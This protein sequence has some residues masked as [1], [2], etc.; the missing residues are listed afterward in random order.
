MEPGNYSIRNNILV[1]N[2]P[3]RVEDG[4]CTEFVK[5]FFLEEQLDTYIEYAHRTPGM[6][7]HVGT[8]PRMMVAQ[9]HRKIDRDRILKKAPGALKSK[10][11]Q[12]NRI[13]ISDEKM[14]K[15]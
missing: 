6:P 1:Q 15:H 5:P 14:T 11:F 2:I 7:P 10:Q 8:K 3:E 13:S 4:D 9:W 12:G